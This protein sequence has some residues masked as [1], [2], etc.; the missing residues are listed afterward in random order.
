MNANTNYV[1][2][3]FLFNDQQVRTVV[4]DGEPWFVGKDVAIVLGYGNTK[5]ALLSHIDEEDRAIL[6]RSENATFEIPNRGLTIINE[7]GLYS[8]I[9]SSKLPTAK[10]FKRWVTSEVLPTIRKHGAYMDMDVIEK[11]LTNPDFIIQM[12]TTLKE[13]KQRRMEAEAKIAADEH[14]VDFY[15]AV[16]STSATLTIERF[17]K[18][19]TEKLGIQTG[20]NRMFQWLRKNGFLQANNMPYQRYINNGWFKTYEVIKAGHAFTVPSITGKGQ[21]KLFEKFAAE[22]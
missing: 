18:L 20:R 9:V 22:A 13:E 15:N 14:K 6:Q 19:V 1:T 8:L 5:D 7:S 12:A 4:R 2:K 11:A 3:E 17:A 21:Q 16:G 10:E